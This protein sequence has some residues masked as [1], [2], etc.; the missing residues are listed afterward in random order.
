[1]CARVRACGH[2]QES[3]DLLRWFAD[4]MA[5]DEYIWPTLNH[6]P[7]LHAPG[8]YKGKSAI[9]AAAAVVFSALSK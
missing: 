8:S 2:S 4:T 6:N 1:V 7:Q 3:R 5:P 9:A